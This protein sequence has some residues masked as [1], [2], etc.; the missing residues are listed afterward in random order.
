MTIETYNEAHMLMDRISKLIHLANFIKESKIAVKGLDIEISYEV[1]GCV[2]S[3]ITHKTN[4]KYVNDLDII[5]EAC[6]FQSD[7]LQKQFDAL[8]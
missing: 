6:I 4:L 2:E 3:K 7:K 1:A 5:K 8:K